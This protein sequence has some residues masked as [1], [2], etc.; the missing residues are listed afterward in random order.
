MYNFAIQYRNTGQLV[1]DT[2]I[3]YLYKKNQSRVRKK[4]TFNKATKIL[5]GN[6]FQLR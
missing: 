4:G 3:I 5:K 6:C 2:K 1:V